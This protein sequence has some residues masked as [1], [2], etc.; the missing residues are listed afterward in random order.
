V[1]VTEALPIF[2][3]VT[4]IVYVPGERFPSMIEWE[5]G[6]PL[7]TSV[8]PWNRVQEETAWSVVTVTGLET[9]APFSGERMWI[10]DWTPL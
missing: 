8:V 9:V 5:E 7:L 3:P 4:S 2:P 6:P 10:I 1:K